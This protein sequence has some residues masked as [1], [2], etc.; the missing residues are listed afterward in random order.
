[1]TKPLS[2]KVNHQLKD[3]IPW[4]KTR[5]NPD[6]TRSLGSAC[7]EKWNADVQ[8]QG[9]EDDEPQVYNVMYRYSSIEKAF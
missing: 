5:S 8:K 1:M 9:C 3:L 4:R 7:C 2:V 6:I